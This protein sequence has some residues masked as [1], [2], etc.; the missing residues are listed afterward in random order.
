MGF[1]ISTAKDF[2]FTYILFPRSLLTRPVGYTAAAEWR[3][4]LK[5][6][7]DMPEFNLSIKINSNKLMFMVIVSANGK[8][9]YTL[10]MK[11]RRKKKTPFLPAVCRA[12]GGQKFKW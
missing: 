2:R 9:T 11:E 1:R 10:Q 7:L 5:N 8:T 3:E 4:V 6:L 12:F